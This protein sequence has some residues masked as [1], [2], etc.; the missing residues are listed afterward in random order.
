[1]MWNTAY[2]MMPAPRR[3]GAPEVG[4]GRAVRIADRW[5]S[6]HRA[7]L[8]AAEADQFPGYHTLHT[9]RDH[10]IVGTDWYH[11]GVSREADAAPAPFVEEAVRDAADRLCDVPGPGAL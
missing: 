10:H 8:H 7:G 2:G 1:M 11:R 9:L 3:P 4:S 6:E 5:L